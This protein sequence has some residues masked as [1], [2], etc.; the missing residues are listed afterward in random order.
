MNNNV[1]IVT[2]LWDLGRGDIDGWAKRDFSHYKDKFFE[3]LK[4]DAQMCVWI[5]EILRREVEEIRGDK[6]T[7]IFIK[8]NSDFDTWNPFFRRMQEIRNDP[9]WR[10]SAGWL[11]ESPQA[12]LEYY[13]AMMFTKMFMIND[14]AI[15][16]PFSSEYFFWMDGGLT[17]T[18]NAGYFLHD[19]VLDNLDRYVLKNG[20]KFVFISYPYDGNEEIH[21][22]ERKA[23]A[24][25]CDV[26]FVNYV[27]RGGFFGGSKEKVH[28]LNDLHYGVMK[29]T[30]DEGLMGAD[31][32]IFTILA[33]RNPEITHRFEISG[34]GLVWPFFEN[35][36]EFTEDKM[37][38]DPSFS[39]PDNTAIYVITFNSPSQ[40][41]ALLQSME[42]YDN[43][44][45]TRPRRKYLLDNSSDLSTTEKYKSICERYGY[46]HIKKDNLGICGGRQFVAEHAEENGFDF[47]MFF[48][49]DMFFYSGPDPYCKN[50]FRRKVAD[51]YKNSINIIRENGFDF[52]KLSFTEFYG[53]NGTQWSWYNIPQDVRGRHFPDKTKLPVMG[54]DPNA[55]RTKFD[56]IRVLNG[57][58]YIGG[59]IYYCNWP[60]VV[61]RSG[62]KKMFLTERW[63]HP[64]EG[65]WMSY[66]FQETK[67]GNILPGLLL[68][69]PTQHERRDFY[70]GKLRKES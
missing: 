68:A 33:H 58:P 15:T 45:I 23:M 61:S 25:Y 2:G 32:C 43:D 41:E 35:L 44:F 9:S 5:P 69:S 16:N 12:A 36:K 14:S 17:N 60:Q 64:Y 53:D 27:C 26:D 50:G 67:K 20:G 52:L 22:F 3:L 30:L 18:V 24:R 31:E 7:K 56:N 19:M 51:L 48:E 55:P 54:T 11:A 13:N 8:N 59:E 38:H 65:T 4:C 66:I 37:R 49:D 1:T 40:F 57:I 46:E 21:G 70:D 62:N 47:Y 10:N 42:T 28:A 63:V 34:D 39:D 6:P 29:S